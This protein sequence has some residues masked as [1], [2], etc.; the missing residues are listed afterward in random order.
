MQ[1]AA[2]N[3][4]T[5]YADSDSEAIYALR[6]ASEPRSLFDL[7]VAEAERRIRGRRKCAGLVHE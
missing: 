7:E 1:L 4:V 3:P 2:L 5:E 6:A